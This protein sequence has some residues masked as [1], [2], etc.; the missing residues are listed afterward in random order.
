M[1]GGWL[2]KQ[3]GHQASREFLKPVAA[4]SSDLGSALHL[5]GLFG[6][7]SPHLERLEWQRLIR[8]DFYMFW[9]RE[10]SENIHSV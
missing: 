5:F 9:I 3:K 2:M 1:G 7:P 4:G 6:L 10:R 8:F